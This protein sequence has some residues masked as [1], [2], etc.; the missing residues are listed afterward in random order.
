MTVLCYANPYSKLCKRLY[1]CNMYTQSHACTTSKVLQFYANA[2]A[3]E[4]SNSWSL[5]VT[6]LTHHSAHTTL[7]CNLQ[8]AHMHKVVLITL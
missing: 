3:F 5:N 2:C 4:I 6:L 7:T 1:A 8:V